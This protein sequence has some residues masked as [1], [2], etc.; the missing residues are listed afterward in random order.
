M[1][2]YIFFLSQSAKSIKHYFEDLAFKFRIRLIKLI[3]HLKQDTAVTFYKFSDN[4]SPKSI[5]YQCFYRPRL[6]K[7]MEQCFECKCI[8]SQDYDYI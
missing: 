7:I 4:V 3:L 5:S 8:K 6:Q 1:I 2:I